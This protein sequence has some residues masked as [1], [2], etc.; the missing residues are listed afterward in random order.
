MEACVVVAL[1]LFILTIIIVVGHFLWLALA[2]LLRALNDSS[3]TENPQPVQVRDEPVPQPYAERQLR[4]LDGAAR[5]IGWLMHTGRLPQ[6]VG[7]S[8]LNALEKRRGEMRQQLDVVL[9]GRT[10]TRPRTDT[11]PSDAIIAS[12]VLAAVSVTPQANEIPWALPASVVISTMAEAEPV[13][14]CPA[15]SVVVIPPEPRRSF[16]EMMGGFMEERNILWGELVGGL[17]IVG[18]SIALVISLR[19]TL[20]ELPYFPFLIIGAV[21][22]SLIG[23]GRY[24]L[25]HWKLESTSR[26]LLVIGTM[27]VPLSFMVL[28]GLAGGHE[29]GAL[30]VATEAA[31][32]VLFTW[33]VRGATNILLCP[34]IGAAAPRPDWLTTL[35]VLGS[36]ASLL[37]V[38]HIEQGSDPTAGLL[39]LVGYVPAALFVLTQGIVW[40]A[41]YRGDSVSPRQV[42]GL[43][44]GL[45]LSA[46]ALGLAFV[47]LVFRS[48][49]VSQALEYLA[50][51]VALAGLPLLAG[52][53]VAS[54]RLR[55]ESEAGNLPRGVAAVIA[56]MLS[57]GGTLVMVLALVA[58]WPHPV[59][60]TVIAA[61]NAVVFSWVAHRFR[62][63][64]AYVPAQV[65]LTVASLTGYHMLAGHLDVTR[66][67]LGRQLL[68]ACFS[69]TSG[70]VLLVLAGLLATIAEWQVIQ[71]RTSDSRCL[72]AGAGVAGLASL[73][74]V[75]L[76][77]QE[78]P[79]RAACVFATCAAGAWLANARRRRTWLTTAAAAIFFGAALFALRWLDT[80]QPLAQTVTWALVVD[81]VVVLVLAILVERGVR[82]SER[83]G[84]VRQAFELPL[85]WVALIASTGAALVLIPALEWDW[86]IGAAL[87]LV[88][89]GCVWLA[90]AWRQRNAVFFA[91][92]QGVL[93]VAV[94]LVCV[95]ILQTE[96]WFTNDLGG[97]LSHVR[98]WQVYGVGLTGLAAAW[99]AARFA[100]KMSERAWQLLE[101]G[102]PTVDRWLL[103]SLVILALVVTA[104]GVAHGAMEEL[105]PLPTSSASAATATTLAV[106]EPLGWCWLGLLASAVALTLWQG[107][108]GRAVLELTGVALCVSVLS[109]AVFAPD[110]AVASAVRWS[111]ALCFVGCS[112]LVWVRNHL[113]CIATGVGIRW[114]CGERIGARVRVLLIAGA[115]VPVLVLTADVAGIGFARV[116]TSGPNAGSFFARVGP[117]VNNLAP[118][119]L[120]C[121]GLVGHGVR[122]RSAGYAFGA[123]QV[124]LVTMVGGYALG[125]ITAGGAI[126][127][128]ESV[129]LGQIATGVT[130]AWLLGWLGVRRALNR[131][132][133]QEQRCAQL[134]AVQDALTWASYLLWLL[135][136]L[137][138]LAFPGTF[139]PRSDE[140]VA[141]KAQA[142]EWLGW[143]VVGAAAGAG[144]G[145]RL[146]ARRT[147]PSWFVGA[148]AV[149]LG[150]VAS[151]TVAIYAPDW[152]QRTLM[153]VAAVLALG[154][155]LTLVRWSAAPPR[156]L[157]TSTDSVTELALVCGT[158]A[159]AVLI[160]VPRAAAVN[161]HYWS[162]AAVMFVALAATAAALLQRGEK[163]MFVATLLAMLAASLVVCRHYP[164]EPSI[165]WVILFFQVNLAMA[166]LVG[167]LWLYF[168]RRISPDAQV[169]GPAPFWLSLQHYLTFFG[170]AGLLG[171][172]FLALVLDPGTPTNALILSV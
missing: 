125:I 70:V 171:L 8:A 95:R 138:L 119:V 109:A 132:L 15:E 81:A 71:R 170:N 131:T 97:L 19:E 149:I 153:L 156:W 42:G 80:G 172:A 89:V 60:L 121:V 139:A 6:E 137:A 136:A 130:A 142:G 127:T 86:L 53:T 52:G 43:F 100:L 166:G 124:A 29:R 113:A 103:G 112:A 133:L 21:T 51:P 13:T 145:Y 110:V 94:V 106:Q 46:Y 65:C 67:E 26:G 31:A 164:G 83:S 114:D 63:T 151:C 28:A 27:M 48:D 154:F 116:Y 84:S 11:L 99:V 141:M 146:S 158:G 73:L 78:G 126:G 135:P 92:F 123:G 24:T 16:A 57:L 22:A 98:S 91:A 128:R 85:Q 17:L 33:L 32:L 75:A 118:L 68:A 148:V 9:H 12:P 4:E 90:L 87:A 10:E 79:G 66:P 2:A 152:D 143:L 72:S 14:E 36:S 76:D 47:F 162:A 88:T 54:A 107:Q 44:L 101:P 39:G 49:N 157:V 160:G 150:G 50:I 104:V 77:G 18:C 20:E 23:A 159:L 41:V 7:E 38:P 82:G 161:D 69:P 155:V 129:Q 115:V 37:A 35:A 169:V 168:V 117:V 93:A 56:T 147:V 105:T 59:R 1:V 167:L 144:A 74:L 102:W 108:V 34:A 134:L 96:P 163:W 40:H 111:L 45:G 120:L 25:S 122:E 55:G 61:G 3:G 140:P 64:P 62:L 58:A 5:Q 165:A 30:E